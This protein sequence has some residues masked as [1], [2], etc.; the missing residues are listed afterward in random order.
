MWL[1]RALELRFLVFTRATESVEIVRIVPER[2]VFVFAAVRGL[3][4]DT[5]TCHYT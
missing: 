4:P 2:V 1:I 3:F 5:V